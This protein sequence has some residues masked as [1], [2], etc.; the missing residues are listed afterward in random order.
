[1][2]DSYARPLVLPVPTRLPC[3]QWALLDFSTFKS[4][5]DRDIPKE[6]AAKTMGESEAA[7]EYGVSLSSVKRVTLVRSLSSSTEGKDDRG[8][9]ID[10]IVLLYRSNLSYGVKTHP[11]HLRVNGLPKPLEQLE[12]LLLTEHQFASGHTLKLE[13]EFRLGTV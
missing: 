8:E 5:L 4:F 12:L 2:R 9:S 13:N 10:A 1:L 6:Q 11:W 7:Y 3:R